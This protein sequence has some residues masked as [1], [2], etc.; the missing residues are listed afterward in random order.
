MGVEMTDTQN[1]AV[2]D[3]PSADTGDF[4]RIKLC[5]TVD[6]VYG[7]EPE[8]KTAWAKLTVAVA[9]RRSDGNVSTQYVQIS[10]FGGSA[11]GLIAAIVGPGARVKVTGEMQSH[12]RQNLDA[13]KVNGAYPTLLD[14]RGKPVFETVLVVNDENRGQIA[15]LSAG[16]P[17]P[18]A[19]SEPP[20]VDADDFDTV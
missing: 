11:Q 6:R 7:G 2:A 4:A 16:E 8:G 18:R 1:A 3:A 9:K 13:P 10:I 12:P 14:G 5:G 15:V 19:T 17:A 20:P